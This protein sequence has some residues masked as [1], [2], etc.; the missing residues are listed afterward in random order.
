MDKD[1]KKRMYDAIRAGDVDVI[2]ELLAGNPGLLDL[3]VLGGSWMSLAAKENQVGALKALHEAGANLEPDGELPVSAA[4]RG[5]AP[6]AL[7]WLLTRGVGLN[8]SITHRRPLVSAIDTGDPALVRRILEAG[9]D[10][11]F[12]WGDFNYTPVS[13]ARTFGDSHSEIVAILEGAQ[14]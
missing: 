6:G 1:A 13:Y 10:P 9:A 12:T 14:E 3:H 4:I 5:G 11:N 2:T 7:D 8:D